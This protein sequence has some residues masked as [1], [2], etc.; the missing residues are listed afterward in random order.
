MELHKDGLVTIATE[1][2]WLKHPH[3]KAYEALSQLRK[4]VLLGHVLKS[5]SNKINLVFVKKILLFVKLFSS[6][7]LMSEF[8]IWFAFEDGIGG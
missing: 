5:L 7:S 3:A 1:L 8:D 6:C 2:S 4:L